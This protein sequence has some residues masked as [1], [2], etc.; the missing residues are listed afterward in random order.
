MTKIVSGAKRAPHLLSSQIPKRGKRVESYSD[1]KNA[2][3]RGIMDDND[4]ATAETLVPAFREWV[5]LTKGKCLGRNVNPTCL[6]YTHKISSVNGY[7][8]KHLNSQADHVVPYN[9]GGS[10][11]PGN[12]VALCSPCNNRKGNGPV[13]D[14]LAD[15]PK[16]LQLVKRFARRHGFV[17]MSVAYYEATVAKVDAILAGVDFSYI[18]FNSENIPGDHALI[19]DLWGDQ[20]RVIEHIIAENVV[21]SERAHVVRHLRGLMTHAYA[22]YA[23]GGKIELT[24]EKRHKV[25]EAYL[26][27]VPK[28][29][30]EVKR[31]KR[32]ARYWNA[33]FGG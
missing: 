33:Y 11:K 22:R 26:K 17:P 8:M 19:P 29:A 20:A 12:M 23:K 5:L 27:A 32:A 14:F 2:L 21:G 18:L 25:I 16:S 1:I 31:A 15:D 13:E 6:E 10:T 9:R 3:V 7:Y 24:A 28:S 30:S 4:R